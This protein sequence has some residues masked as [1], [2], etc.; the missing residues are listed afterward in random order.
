MQIAHQTSIST[1]VH[2]NNEINVQT[3]RTDQAGPRVRRRRV[4][5][6]LRTRAQCPCLRTDL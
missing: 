5:E 1:G 2:I 6:L 3:R 4:G